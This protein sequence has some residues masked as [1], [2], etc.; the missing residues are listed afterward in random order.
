MEV[1][2]DEQIELVYICTPNPLH[3]EHIMLCLS[4]KKHVLCEK[5]FVSNHSQLKECFAYAKQQGC[6][7]ME[8]EKTVF[9]PLNRKLKEMVEEGAIGKLRYIEAGYCAHMDIEKQDPSSWLFHK[10]DGGCFYDV[11]VYPICYANY[12]AGSDI[13]QIQVM[14]HV[15][16]GVGIDTF[17][18]AMLKYDNEVMAYVRS[19]WDLRTINQGYLYGEDGVIITNNFWKNTKAI[20]RKDGVDQTIEVEMHSDFTG[21]IE[22]A[23][24]CVTQGLLQSPIL[25]Q[26]HSEQIMNVLEEIHSDDCVQ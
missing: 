12:F 11:G 26:K 10:E 1:M 7:L 5:P 22:H 20:L 18:Q 2:K 23:C 13:Q 4:H 9:T 19:S 17:T 14:K 16:K 3:F 8:A 25:S 6:F 15:H 21:E 24:D